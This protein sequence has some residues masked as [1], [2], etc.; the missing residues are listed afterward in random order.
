MEKPM[1]SDAQALTP[2]DEKEW[3]KAAPT[4]FSCPDCGGV[5]REVA[6]GHEPIRYRCRI[7]HALTMDSLGD[8]QEA[9]LDLAL[10]SA[11]RALSENADLCRRV[12]RRLSGTDDLKQGYEKKAA[13]AEAEAALIRGVLLDRNPAQSP[14]T[15]LLSWALSLPPA[16]RADMARQ[17]LDS[18]GDRML[19]AQK[20]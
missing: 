11:L 8:V 7:G 16:E 20:Q 18:L 5:L 13:H 19:S 17:M 2:A 6:G 9:A 15:E 3:E 14:G 12:A 1:T 10:S 4:D